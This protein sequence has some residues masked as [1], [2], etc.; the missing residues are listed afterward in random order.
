MQLEM[1]TEMQLAGVH[2][3][4]DCHVDADMLGVFGPSGAGKTTLLLLIAGL[5][6][7]KRGRIVL[8]D[9][10]LFDAA[11]GTF[12]PP[13][14]RRIGVVFQDSRLFPHLSVRG[15]L[16]FARRLARAE[17]R[18]CSWRS[19]VAMLE[20]DG[21]L[22]RRIGTLSGGERQLVAMARALLS[23]PRL[24][25]LDEP[26]SAI[27]TGRQAHLLPMLRRVAR[28]L[29]VPM[30]I[31]SHDLT[32]LLYLTDRLLLVEGGRCVAEGPFGI[33]L[34]DANALRLLRTGR[35]TNVLHLQVDRHLA[36][37]GL[38]LQEGEATRSSRRTA[39][40]LL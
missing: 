38:T 34:H 31:V 16:R 21:L 13:H 39:V 6:R 1:R 18:R 23:S 9:E 19:V 22:D 20:L 26:V 11:K 32:P 15:N 27:D 5:L 24:L 12:V 10:V 37:E 2:F 25:L 33:L 3:A 28:E 8:D 29:H 30:V 7:P 35:I 4:Y 17:A 36:A 14:R 40:P